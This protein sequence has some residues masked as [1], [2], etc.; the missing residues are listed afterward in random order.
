MEYRNLEKAMEIFS[1][2][3]MGDEVSKTHNVDLYEAFSTNAQVADILELMLKKSNLRL[4]EYNYALYMTS[5]ENNRVFGFTNE[6]LKKLIGLRL[7]R[8]L[9]LAYFIIF[10][11]VTMFYNDSGS[12]SGTAYVR[13]EYVIEKVSG[14]LAQIMPKLELVSGN[15]NEESSFETI[16]LL[17]AD[18]P[19][20]TANDD[21]ATLKA[22]RGTKIG[23]VKLV[24]N[25]LQEQDLFTE[26]GGRYYA[27][28][29]FRALVENYYEDGRSRLYEIAVKGGQTE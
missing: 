23:F 3:L 10:Q 21:M 1:C 9:F 11:V 2:L 27:R 13:A 16:S 7:N 22:A 28:D 12:A 20:M 17:W 24:F 8:E 5:G 6:E 15:K 29:R 4:Y 25:F 26:T 18:M 19:M 14:A